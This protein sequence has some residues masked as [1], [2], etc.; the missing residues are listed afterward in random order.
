MQTVYSPSSI[1]LLISASHGCQKRRPLHRNRRKQCMRTCPAHMSSPG[2]STASDTGSCPPVASNPAFATS[3]VSAHRP[4]YPCYSRQ[5]SSLPALLSLIRLTGLLQPQPSHLQ[6]IPACPPRSRSA[7]YPR[8]S[9]APH[10]PR[11]RSQH[12]LTPAAAWGTDA[13]WVGHRRKSRAPSPL[14][15]TSEARSGCSGSPC[16]QCSRW[17]SGS[18]SAAPGC[19]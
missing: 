17:P 15:E 14:P 19:P 7:G 6:H 5:L 1:A 18:P 16:P 12:A 8:R 4:C 2:L 9:A 11:T 10:R 3:Q 13:S